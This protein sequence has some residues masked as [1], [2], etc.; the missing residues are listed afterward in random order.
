MITFII[1]FR[2]I[3]VQF[4]CKIFCSKYVYRNEKCSLT[5]KL[6]KST[7][8]SLVTS[9]GFVTKVRC[10]IKYPWFQSLS[11]K[12]LHFLKKKKL[13]QS[14]FLLE[15]VTRKRFHEIFFLCERISRISRFFSTIYRSACFTE[16]LWNNYNC[17]NDFTWQFDEKKNQFSYTRLLWI[18]QNYYL[19]KRI[20]LNPKIHFFFFFQAFKELYQLPK[21]KNQQV[22]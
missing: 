2:E 18:S 17:R 6:V 14:A 12:L 4:I 1:E 20:F 22:S 3:N 16:K 9:L 21:Q 7:P 19:R 11:V 13:V 10:H 5:K 8:Y 15:K